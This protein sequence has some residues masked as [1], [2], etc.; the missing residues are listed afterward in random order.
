MTRK[1]KESPACPVIDLVRQ[2]PPSNGSIRLIRHHRT[3][4]PR[5]S[6]RADTTPRNL[7][8]KPETSAL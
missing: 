3:G 4:G 2:A 8:V 6:L 5:H 7:D 1:K